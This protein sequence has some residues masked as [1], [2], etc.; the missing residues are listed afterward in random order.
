M[1]VTSENKR[2]K[3][4]RRSGSRN[5]PRK[6]NRNLPMILGVGVLVVG[7]IAFGMFQGIGPLVGWLT[8]G[9][10]VGMLIY[11][12]R[13]PRSMWIL[14]IGLALVIGG[15]LG[16]LVD[17]IT[18]G[19]VLDFIQTPLRS[20]IFN[21][22]DMMIHLGLILSVIGAYLQAPPESEALAGSPIL[23][24]QQIETESH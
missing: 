13:V 18:A 9:V 11:M 23:E 7:L 3:R 24:V 8:I 16:N 2:G 1:A 21:V 12:S 20:G 6:S 22:A 14:R 17:R 4:S 19:E 10:V 15:A 5:G